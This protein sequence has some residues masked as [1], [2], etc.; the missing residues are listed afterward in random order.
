MHYNEH[1]PANEFLELLASNSDLP[2][3]IQP[4]RHTSRSRTFIDNISRNINSK[5]GLRFSFVSHSTRHFL[6]YFQSKLH[7]VDLWQVRLT[8]QYFLN[9]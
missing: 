3:I 8:F 4:S 6:A 7:S 5:D 9:W 1:K 2:Y